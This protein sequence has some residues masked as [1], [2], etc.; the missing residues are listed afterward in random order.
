MSADGTV[1]TWG[2]NAAGQLCRPTTDQIDNEAAPLDP[3]PP[4]PKPDS[5]ASS[6]AEDNRGGKDQANALL[7]TCAPFSMLFAVPGVG[8]YGCGDSLDGSLQPLPPTNPGRPPPASAPP[9]IGKRREAEWEE[10]EGIG[11]GTE[12]GEVEGD[13]GRLG[14]GVSDGGDGRMSRMHMPPS[15]AVSEPI[16]Q[17]VSGHAHSLA[18]RASG[19]LFAWGSN[20]F[21]QLGYVAPP[22][23]P[24]TDARTPQPPR[25]IILTSSLHRGGGASSE[26]SMARGD[27]EQGES[28]SIKQIAAGAYHT[29]VLADSGEVWSFGW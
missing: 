14:G 19:M 5:V 29:L 28:I 6:G 11:D 26:S 23:S 22:P 1:Y 13:G 3:Q 21:G 17:M 18:L 25:A 20:E 9:R 4:L 7:M 16:V 15:W 24:T 12:E 2:E 8:V 10:E 27:V